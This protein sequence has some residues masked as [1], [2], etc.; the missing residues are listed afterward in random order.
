[1]RIRLASYDDLPLNKILCFSV[2]D[3]LCEAVFEIENEYYPQIH[4]NKCEYECEY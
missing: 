2:L 3:I 1:M 4:I